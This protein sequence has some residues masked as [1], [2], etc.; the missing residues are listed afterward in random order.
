[1]KHNLNQAQFASLAKVSTQTI[2]RIESGSGGHKTTKRTKNKIN[3]F[4]REYKANKP[5]VVKVHN[6]RTYTRRP[7]PGTLSDDLLIKI[8]ASELTNEMKAKVIRT[9]V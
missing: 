1:M 7:N 4:M 8:I 6:K 5:E 9:L 3:K 2:S